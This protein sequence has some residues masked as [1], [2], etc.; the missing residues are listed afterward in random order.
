MSSKSKLKGNNFEREVVNL[1]KSFGLKAKRA[2]ASN[3]LSLG[4][5]EDVDIIIENMDFQCKRR[6]KLGKLLRPR[7]GLIQLVREDRGQIFAILPFSTLI[8]LIY[9]HKQKEGD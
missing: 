1:A 5:A 2:Y 8:Q 3:G 6:K 7:E 4:K 9:S